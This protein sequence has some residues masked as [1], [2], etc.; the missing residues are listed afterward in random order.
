MVD[1]ESITTGL[2]KD[3]SGIW[4]SDERKNVSYP[5]D[6][7]EICHNIEDISFWFKHRNNCILSVVK[8]YP[9][10]RG[11]SVFDIGGGNGFVALAIERAGFNVVL[12]EPGLTGAMN[13]KNRGLKNVI[14]ATADA[15][16]FKPH[17]LL[18]VG[19]FNVLEHI[20]DDLSFLK[21]LKRLLKKL[22][23]IYI[24]VPAY[25][26]LW[27]WEDVAA[28]HYRRYTRKSI[29]KVIEQAGFEV[30]FSSYIFRF[31]PIPIAVFRV[32]PYR[33]GISRPNNRAPNVGGDHSVQGGAIASMLAFVLNSEIENL[34]NNK[35]MSFGGSCLIVA[36]SP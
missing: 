21:S 16:R 5:S 4:F 35:A 22:G 10:D 36:K 12:V 28:G 8:S 7:N 11:G 15:A 26:F 23:R 31:L 14:C 30:E 18:A 34:K 9:P 1:I 32:L 13:G 2:K 27:S 29:C 25:S 6:G 24:T 3:S 20:E 19:L 33:I 17:S